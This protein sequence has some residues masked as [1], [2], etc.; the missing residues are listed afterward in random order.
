[1]K[2]KALLPFALGA[3]VLSAGCSS[4][5]G[6]L[7]GA[8]SRVAAGSAERSRSRGTSKISHVIVIIQEN[9]SFE[10]FFAGFPGA[11][12]PMTGCASP[13]PGG[14]KPQSSG[15]GGCP[16]G[17]TQ[18][19]LHQVTFKNNP[20]LKHD[21]SSSMVDCNITASS[22]CNMDGFSAWGMSHGQYSAY[23]YLDRSE[24]QPYWT[25]AQQYVLADEMFPTEFGGS[26]TAHLTLVAGTDDIKLPGR[27]EV[28]FPNAAPDDCD[29]P[30]GTK[31]SYIS[32]KPYRHIHPWQGGFPCFDQF[33]TMAQVLDNAGISWRIYSSKLLDAGFWEPFEAIRYTRYGP[34]WD[35]DVSA[36]QTNVLTDAQNGNLA[37]VSWVTP[38]GAD[39]DH[40]TY[41]SDLGPSWVSSVVNAIG[42]S[43]YWSSSAI[44]VL[45]DDWGGFYDNAPPPQLDYR[46]LGIRVGCL[47]ISPYAKTNYVSHVQYEFGSILRFIEEVNGLP[48]GSIGSV[49]QGYTD[50]RATSLD[51]AFN[52]NQ[53]PRPFKAI[54]SKYPLSHFL[55]EPPSNAPVDTE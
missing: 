44:I 4:S 49:E 10:N 22:V 15:S 45:W 18:V 41:K 25:M 30:K 38:S 48:A 53:A 21:W 40:P 11:N 39:S 42:G 47:I 28:D 13:A 23:A 8:S 55:H 35:N 26:F 37:T 43:Q 1:M 54:P 31:S 14:I 5:G 17:D 16:Y 6:T 12:A 2:F 52:F 51:D 24:V 19:S 20:D 32:Q 9:R 50:A 33:N 34:D 29:S 3:I 46:G 27:A 7:T 36:P